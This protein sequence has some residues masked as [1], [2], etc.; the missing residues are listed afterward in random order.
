MIAV[1]RQDG[2]LTLIGSMQCPF[3][4]EKALAP[5]LGHKRMNVVQATTGGGFGGK[6]EYPSMLAAHCALLA[7]KS[8]KPVKMVYRRD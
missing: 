7:I 8:G 4:I 6:E 3:Y 1:L 2:G 5:M